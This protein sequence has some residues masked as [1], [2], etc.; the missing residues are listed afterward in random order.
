M[1]GDNSHIAFSE[2][3]TVT[4]APTASNHNAPSAAVVAPAKDGKAKALSVT[5]HLMPIHEVAAKYTVS[6]NEEKP[7]DSQGLTADDAAKRLLEYGPNCLTPPKKRHWF[8]RFMDILL[9]LFNLML[10]VSGIACYVLLAIDY[11]A[12]YQ[13]TYLGAILLGVAVMNALIEF[14][15]E[16]KSA[17]ILEST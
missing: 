16:Q 13:N 4:A 11:S 6:I 15:Q 3:N 12:N 14:Y 5:E 10:I 2:P 9:G 1:A 8:L 17:A 7:G